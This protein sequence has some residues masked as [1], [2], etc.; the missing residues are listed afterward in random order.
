MLRKIALG[1]FLLFLFSAPAAWSLEVYRN[2]DVSLDVGFWGQAWYQNVS[3]M[4]TDD[5]GKWDDDLNDFMVRRAYFSVK[6][7]V[8]PW[9]S[10]FVHYAGDRLGQDELTNNSGKGLGSGL[11]LRDG[12]GTVKL[13]GDDF[14]IQA[15]RMYIPFTRNYGTTSTKSLLTTELDWGQGG[16]RSGIFYPSNIGRDD[17]VTLWGNILDDKLQYR[18]MVAD[19]EDED[20]RNPD[21]NLRFAGR[22]SYNF[23]DAETKWFNAGTYLGKKRI[24]AVGCGGDTQQDLILNGQ[25]EDYQGWTVDVHYDQ[26]TG[27]GALTFAAAYIDVE[28]TVNGVTWT[29][30]D[31]GEDFATVSAKLGYFFDRKIGPGQFQPFIHYENFDAKESG[32]KDTDVYGIGLNYYLKGPANKLSIDMT[33]VDQDREIKDTAKQNRTILT[34]QLAFGF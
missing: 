24:L 25:E 14:M 20:G 8:N 26:P 7:T 19:G 22:L 2:G 33:F 15:G 6:G 16:T 17:G 5:D 4:D 9:I 23:F 18:F 29:D 12:W 34:C 21:D 11:A 1:A 13:L 10:F 31:S 30:I 3:D 28:N 27:N 32:D